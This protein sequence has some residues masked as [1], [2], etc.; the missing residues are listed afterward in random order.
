MVVATLD[1]VDEDDMVQDNDSFVVE[2]AM[3]YILLPEAADDDDDDDTEH[4]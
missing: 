1:N 4:L 2:K 3:V